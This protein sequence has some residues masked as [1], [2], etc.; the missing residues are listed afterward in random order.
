VKPELVAEVRYKESRD[1]CCGN[2]LPAVPGRQ[3]A[4]ECVIE[5]RVSG[6]W[7]MPVRDRRTTHTHHAVQFTNLAKVFW[8][9]RATPRAT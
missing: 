4:E 2:R 9:T 8:P 1:G 6:P 7:L 5:K 3:E